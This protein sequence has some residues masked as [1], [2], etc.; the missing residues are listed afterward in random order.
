MDN[1]L[2]FNLKNILLVLEIRR[3]VFQLLAFDNNQ[4]F[5]NVLSLI[6]SPIPP[7]TTSIFLN[8][9]AIEANILNYPIIIALS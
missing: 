1:I 3:F 6:I 2:R 7:I 5:A 4:I 9:V 8:P